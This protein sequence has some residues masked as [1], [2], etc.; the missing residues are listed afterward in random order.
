MKITFDLD[1]ETKKIKDFFNAIKANDEE[2]LLKVLKN[3]L[4]DDISIEFYV[5][6][7]QKIGKNEWWK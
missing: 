6:S 5:K 7:K 2:K 3:I 4:L 1:I